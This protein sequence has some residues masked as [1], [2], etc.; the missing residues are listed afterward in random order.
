[1]RGQPD[2]EGLSALVTGATS[3]IGKAA[4]EEL[5]RHGAEVV[6]HGRDASRGEAAVDAI[7]GKGGK[8]RFI[9][10]DLSQPAELD[11]LVQQAG[12]VDVLVSNA[13]FSWFG[14]TADLDIATFD[15]LFAD[16]DVA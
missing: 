12:V 11:D 6:V 13:G 7:A 16:G 8:A 4:A 3:G 9:A 10:A 5:A 1:M 14:P 15:A 2:L